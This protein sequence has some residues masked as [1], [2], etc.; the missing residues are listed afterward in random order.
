MKPTQKHVHYFE[1]ILQLRPYN[2][3][4]LGF[5]LDEIEKRPGTFI[6]KKIEYKNGLDLYLSSNAF[7]KNIGQKLKKK[8]KGNLV[9]SRALYSTSRITS[10]TLYR[11]TVLFRME[12]KD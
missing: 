2:D 11:L 4:V 10:K 3:E 6:S 8:F 12:E 7:A 1:A 5:I 9:M